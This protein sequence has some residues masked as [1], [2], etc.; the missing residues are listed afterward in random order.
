MAWTAPFTATVGQIIT[1]ANWNQQIRDN[2]LYLKG[3]AGTVQ[4]EAGLESS[5]TAGYI[6]AGVLTTTQRDA[7]TGSAGMVIYNSDN[8]KFEKYEGGAWRAD[9]AYDGTLTNLKVPS[10]AQ[11]DVFYA[12]TGTSI[13][14]L[15][16]GTSGDFLKTQGAGAN[17]LW[18]V[19][20]VNAALY[21]N[22]ANIT[23][24]TA[25]YRLSDR[26]T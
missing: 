18:G 20:A 25:G 4:I 22:A 3:Q 26:K 10:Q 12:D 9:L 21:V 19:P 1:A 17:P 6:R 7:L 2:E 11:G 5:G 16:A 8:A 23:L 13:A 24:A 14:R 15:G